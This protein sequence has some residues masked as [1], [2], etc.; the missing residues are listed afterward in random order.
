MSKEIEIISKYL[1]ENGKLPCI[2]GFAVASKLGV[3]TCEIGAI[4][5][6]LGIRVTDCELGVFGNLEFLDKDEE[7]YSQIIKKANESKQI[8]CKTLWDEAKKSS[9]KMVGSTVKNSDIEVVYCQLGCF[10][11]RSHS[12]RKH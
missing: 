2:K 9:L 11:T 7:I 10:R 6:E 4:T 8:E 5:K 3:S 1:D 12:G